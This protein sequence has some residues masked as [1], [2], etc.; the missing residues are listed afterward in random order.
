MR[1]DSSKLTVGVDLSILSQGVKVPVTV[2]F[3][4]VPH[5][6]IVAPSGSGKTYLLTYILGQIAKKSV[7]LILADFKGI[8]LLNLMTVGITISIILSV[9]LLIVFLMNYKT[10]WQMQ[11]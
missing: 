2:D 7:K 3:S 8:V 1:F 6:L 11:V 4:S 10:E 9:K 5:M